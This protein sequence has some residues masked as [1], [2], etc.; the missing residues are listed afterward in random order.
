[1]GVLTRRGVKSILRFLP[2]E[3]LT[4]VIA[5]CRPRDQVALCRATRLFNDLVTRVL[6][7]RINLSTNQAV[8]NWCRSLSENPKL[9]LFVLVLELNT[10]PI[11]FTTFK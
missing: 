7:R 9:S 3:L 10:W 11:D 1:M 2:N 6:Y 4:E 5:W 8:Q